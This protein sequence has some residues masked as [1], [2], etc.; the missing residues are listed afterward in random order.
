MRLI[1]LALLALPLA[2]QTITNYQV[3]DGPGPNCATVAFDVSGLGAGVA[4]TINGGP[5]SSVGYT[6]PGYTTSTND[7]HYIPYCRGLANSPTYL[8]ITVGAT[9]LN[10]AGACTDCDSGDSSI[11]AAGGSD[12]NCTAPGEPPWF[13]TTTRPGDIAPVAPTHAVTDPYA[14]ATGGSVTAT[15]C[16]SL[17]TDFNAVKTAGGVQI[18]EVDISGGP[19]A[20]SQMTLTGATNRVI[21]QPDIDAALFVSEFARIQTD[22]PN[23]LHFRCSDPEI[24][25]GIVSNAFF[26][27]GPNVTFRQTRFDC[28]P[29]P[30]APTQVGVS[31]VTTASRTLG[32]SSACPTGIGTRFTEVTLNLPGLTAYPA[33]AQVASCSGSNLV[34]SA[35]IT[36]SGTYTSGGTVTWGEALPVSG[37]TT[38]ANTRLTVTGHGLPTGSP[39]GQ[40][41]IAVW[42]TGSLAD[43]ING[44]HVFTVVDANTIELTGV[45]SGGSYTAS[46]YDYVSF[47]SALRFAMIDVNGDA[48]FR[49]L[50]CILGTPWYGQYGGRGIIG[51][52]NSPGL[53][54]RDSV[55]FA[56]YPSCPI[57]P[58]TNLPD[59]GTHGAYGGA[60]ISFDGTDDVQIINN[61]IYDCVG[62]C[63]DAQSNIGTPD[64]VTIARNHVRASER[65]FP[66]VTTGNFI[67]SLGRWAQQRHL[68]E[69]KAGCRNCL[70]EGNYL[71]GQAADLAQ[72]QGYAIWINQLNAVGTATPAS[73]KDVK[74]A[75]N[76]IERVSA[77]FAIG[78]SLNK[79][80]GHNITYPSRFEFTDNICIQDWFT[81][82]IAPGSQGST[83]KAGG[84][85]YGGM[86]VLTDGGEM[87]NISRNTFWSCQ[88]NSCPQLIYQAQWLPDLVMNANI[89]PYHR[90]TSGVE[91]INNFG[92][93]LAPITTT[94]YLTRFQSAAPGSSSSFANLLIGG[95]EEADEVSGKK[96]STANADVVTDAEIAADWPS[97]GEFTGLGSV[98]GTSYAGRHST[99]FP[100]GSLFP[101]A[102]YA[103]YGPSSQA[104]MMDK[105]GMTRELIVDQTA[106]DA[107]AFSWHAPTTAGCT[108]R[109]SD[110]DF[111]T[112]QADT[113][114]S[115]TQAQSASFASLTPGGSYRALVECPDGVT[116]KWAQA[117][118]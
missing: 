39:T 51:A 60:A 25:L 65:L 7:T 10:C 30:Y 71:S 12:L 64:N 54:V 48:N 102:A 23:V 42:V 49:C 72:P 57:S 78:N 1:L 98:S 81:R 117:L 6:R 37:V 100:G 90:T 89:M 44:T 34:L 8:R 24:L 85:F 94:N 62:I 108:V 114:A 16:A 106:S 107:L 109:L 52:S 28:D 43:E 101:A 5:T 96:N 61:T 46:D 56:P 31:T 53:I 80:I 76:L 74:F 86:V 68:M 110:D 50:Q 9:A 21:I 26:T 83:A 84:V 111:A 11:F 32:L 59:C 69:L 99:V 63:F 87:F 82:R 47:F 4:V 41:Y 73:V 113:D 38:G 27:V 35:G 66:D 3:V 104:I 97:T 58:T 91:G 14:E 20:V 70:I 18:L 33:H 116:L 92:P 77:C 103:S 36:L 88:A 19:C 15:D 105:L 55:I 40:N 29:K 93:A 75:W 17:A 79:A 22:E 2:S 112:A 95:V 118:Q 67:G 115:A 13:Q 45:S